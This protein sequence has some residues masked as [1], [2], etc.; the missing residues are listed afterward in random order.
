MMGQEVPEHIE[1]HPDG[2]HL[3]GKDLRLTTVKQR[4]DAAWNKATTPDCTAG[5]DGHEAKTRRALSVGVQDDGKGRRKAEGVTVRKV[6]M[7]TL[8]PPL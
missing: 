8:K 3:E 6:G 7:K 4:R 5:R 1:G 2:D